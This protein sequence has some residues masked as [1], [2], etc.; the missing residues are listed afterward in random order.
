MVKQLL[1]IHKVLNV[2]NEGLWEEMGRS[3]HINLQYFIDSL[4]F[5]YQ[6]WIA[7]KL[8]FKKTK[9]WESLSS[10]KPNVHEIVRD[11]EHGRLGG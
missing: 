3:N 6:T 8:K 2:R 9:R 7:N 5:L 11:E 10:K 1:E 4:L